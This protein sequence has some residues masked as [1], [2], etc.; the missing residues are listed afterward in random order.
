MAAEPKVEEVVDEV[1]IEEVEE[2]P[3]GDNAADQ[4]E[5]NVAG[6]SR[7]SKSEKKARKQ[8]QKLG[9]RPIT[10]VTRVTIKKSKNVIFAIT[11]PDVFKSPTSDT[12]VLFGEVKVD[13]F[14]QQTGLQKAAES[15]DTAAADDDDIPALEDE[16]E[17]GTVEEVPALEGDVADSDI[18]LVMKQ[19][20]ATR[21]QAIDALKK[22]DGDVVNAIMELTQ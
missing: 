13:D 4:A 17:S 12:Y 1:K 5:D 22:S 15:L 21:E 11:E 14:G 8:I 9:L 6:R 20:E 18:D 7:Q 10:D 3:E 2:S 19:T 16:N